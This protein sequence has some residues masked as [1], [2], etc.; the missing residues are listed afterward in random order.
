M[1]SAAIDVLSADV[2][3]TAY[4][5]FR[6]VYGDALKARDGG[7]GV[8]A[9]FLL[10]RS[11][12][13]GVRI[14][15][16]AR[17]ERVPAAGDLPDWCREQSEEVQRILMAAFLRRGA[18]NRFAGASQLDGRL[19]RALPAFDEMWESGRMRFEPG[20]STDT[21][22]FP[23][24]RGAVRG[25]LDKRRDRGELVP[26]AGR[27]F[28][29]VRSRSPKTGKEYRDLLSRAFEDVP[30]LEGLIV[31]GSCANSEEE[32]GDGDGKDVDLAVVG[33]GAWFRR[34]FCREGGIR[35]DMLRF[36]VDVLEAGV[37][38][39]DDLINNGLAAS[40]ILVDRGGKLAGLQSKVREEYPQG[41]TRPEGERRSAIETEMKEWV[42]WAKPQG[43]PL[44]DWVGL[45][46][47]LLS[48]L[49]LGFHLA[50]RWFPP[51]Q[52]IL[53]VLEGWDG[54]A[55]AAVQGFPEETDLADAWERLAGIEGFFAGAT[56][57]E[58][59]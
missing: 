32:W 47:A 13:H 27:F 9:E 55:A 50:G 52:E 3:I 39:E 30:D 21:L 45:E 10:G 44:S 36:P 35:L 31:F 53:R 56:E 51:D 37:E 26:G 41:K 19:R 2:K 16:A 20:F 25:W 40:E 6:R 11:L 18:A 38:S 17:D 43:D 5:K 1:A 46:V 14:L 33:K 23:E 34:G 48:I 49:S 12:L 22:F 59:G 57:P 24:E 29:L 54:Q 8:E 4:L 15:A 58:A 7:P 28:D 42:E